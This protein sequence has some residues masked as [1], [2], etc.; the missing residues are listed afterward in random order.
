MCRQAML[1]ATY[2]LMLYILLPFLATRLATQLDTM[3]N[4]LIFTGR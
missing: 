2:F 3:E 4:S 1:L